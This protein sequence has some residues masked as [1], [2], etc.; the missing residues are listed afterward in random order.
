MGPLEGIR[1]IEFDGLGPAP[2]AAMMLADM[3]AEVLRIDR[4]WEVR[5]T[6]PGEPSKD[7]LNRGRMSVGIDL[8]TPQ[9]VEAVFDLIKTADANAW[10][11]QLMSM[12]ACPK[13]GD[14][15]RVGKGANSDRAMS[16]K[17]V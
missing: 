2:F 10:A 1:A 16:S 12:P 14:R 15:S 7:V 17:V 4:P 8:K 13:C 9:G 3:G 5:S 11:S 6:H